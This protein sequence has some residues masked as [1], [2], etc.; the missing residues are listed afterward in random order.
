MSKSGDIDHLG[1]PY[2]ISEAIPHDMML[3]YF[4]RREIFM[5]KGIWVLTD[6]YPFAMAE[7]AD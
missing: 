4:N 1:I 7:G 6:R 5:I 3:F 2:L